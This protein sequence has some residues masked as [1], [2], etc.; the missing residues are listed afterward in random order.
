MTEI[1]L[2]RHGR[3]DWNDEGRYTGQS[4]V[5]LNGT[6]LAQANALALQLREQ[7][8]LAIYSSDLVRARLTAEIIAQKHNL[9]VIIDER[10]R[11]INQGEWEGLLVQTIRDR[12]EGLWEKRIDNPI[13]VRPPGGETVE[14]VAGRVYA[15]LDEIATDYPAG[16]VLVV[17]HGLVI[18]TV[19]CKNENIPL[20]RAYRSIPENANPVWVNWTVQVNKNNL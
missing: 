7:N 4:D 8:F 2:I 11:E 20:A 13:S 9:P 10:F 17:A 18:A 3:T 1:C 19:I 12:Y 16:R 5:K 15:A 6:G 14:E